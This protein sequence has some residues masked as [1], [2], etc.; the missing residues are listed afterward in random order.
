MMVDEEIDAEQCKEMLQGT[1]DPL[2]SRFRLTYNMVC[3]YYCGPV[4]V[5]FYLLSFV[6]LFFFL[7][8]TR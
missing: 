6:P 8:R 5:Q 7:Q 2:I 3:L 4:S 1:P